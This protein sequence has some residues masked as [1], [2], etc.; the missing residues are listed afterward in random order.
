MFIFSLSFYSFVWCPGQNLTIYEGTSPTEPERSAGHFYEKQKE[1]QWKLEEW[2]TRLDAMKTISCTGWTDM[3][4]LETL[5]IK[6]SS[7][8]LGT[9]LIEKLS[10]NPWKLVFRRVD[11]SKAA[12][13]CTRYDCFH[14]IRLKVCVR[15]LKPNEG[16]T[17]THQAAMELQMNSHYYKRAVLMIDLSANPTL[18]NSWMNL[19]HLNAYIIIELSNMNTISC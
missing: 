11:S 15:V 17:Q 7:N 12:F 6:R 14:F 3:H 2:C 19:L 5:L 8:K 10:R 16:I 4:W 18:T 13:S 9:F 1:L